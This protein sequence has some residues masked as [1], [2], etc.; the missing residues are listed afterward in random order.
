MSVCCLAGWLAKSQQEATSAN[1]LAIN[2]DQFIWMITGK[3]EEPSAIFPARKFEVLVAANTNDMGAYYLVRAL[4]CMIKNI[5]SRAMIIII[6]VD[7]LFTYA[8]N[9]LLSSQI[10]NIETD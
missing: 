8:F 10:N 2:S 6:S 5:I 4:H 3:S 7:S 9:V 1:S